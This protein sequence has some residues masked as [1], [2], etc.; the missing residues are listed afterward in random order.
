[1]VKTYGLTHVA[2]AVQDA[3][4]SSRFYQKVFGAVETYTRSRSGTSRRKGKGSR[5]LP[6][7]PDT[8]P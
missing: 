7:G 8:L 5:A 2:L 1:M 3:E 4:I 6:A